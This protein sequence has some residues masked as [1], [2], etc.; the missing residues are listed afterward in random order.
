MNLRQ[1]VINAVYNA[2][3]LL[4]G[5]LGY[6][7]YHRFDHYAPVVASGADKLAGCLTEMRSLLLEG[8]AHPGVGR[9]ERA[10]SLRGFFADTL[11]GR[12]GERAAKVL[13]DLARRNGFAA[14]V[15]R[16]MRRG[17]G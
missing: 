7:C 12:S 15:P 1:P 17:P 11:D 8:L 9:A 14:P 6:A 4:D 3:N 2:P 16:R 13:I 5:R 10:G